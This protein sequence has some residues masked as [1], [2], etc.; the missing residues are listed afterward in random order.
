MDTNVI[1]SQL[2]IYMTQESRILN[3]EIAGFFSIK[4]A[5]IFEY[6]YANE[7]NWTNIKTSVKKK[8]LEMGKDLHRRPKT[9]KLLEEIVETKVLNIRL[10]DNF[11]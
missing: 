6:S 2:H 1:K 3:G 4:G 9:V 7:W 5:G 8:N 11:F 10:S